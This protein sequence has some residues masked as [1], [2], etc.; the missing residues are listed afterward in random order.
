MKCGI[1]NSNERTMVDDNVEV[2]QVK[3]RIDVLACR[4]AGFGLIG[5][6][7]QQSGRAFCSLH[8]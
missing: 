3:D 5:C 1:D 6:N 7:P 2:Q 8:G 4:I